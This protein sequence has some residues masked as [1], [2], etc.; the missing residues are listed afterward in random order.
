KARTFTIKQAERIRKQQLRDEA[1][2]KKRKKKF[3]KLNNNL[4]DDLDF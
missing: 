3:K 4:F 1:A 2:M